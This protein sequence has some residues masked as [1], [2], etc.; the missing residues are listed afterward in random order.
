MKVAIMQPYLFPY[1]G[2]FQL[3]NLVD[4]FVILDN[5]NF[6]KKGWINK[7][8]ILTKNGPTSINLPVKKMSQNRKI[9]QHYFHERDSNFMKLMSICTDSYA[10][11]PYLNNLSEIFN[12]HI[13]INELQVANYLTSSLQILTKQL[14]INTKIIK[15]SELDINKAHTGED[16]VI[17]I[18]KYLKADQ[19]FNLSGGIEL[20]NPQPFNQVGIEL[21][22]L[23][24]NFT[25]YY[26]Y[27]YNT[28]TPYMSIIDV[29]ANCSQD[30]IKNQLQ[31]FHLL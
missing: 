15:A 28:F 29:I 19:Y 30:E 23:S 20:Y 13:N 27:K 8:Q 4:T 21:K 10:K 22:F 5:V 25:P 24:S 18:C 1:I 9:M 11:S 14:N 17:A 16:R 7:N 26:Q 3:L 12:K 6:I 31:D 2:Y